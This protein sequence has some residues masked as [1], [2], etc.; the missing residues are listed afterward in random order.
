ML[1]DGGMGGSCIGMMCR[2]AAVWIVRE[3]C[4]DGVVRK[5]MGFAR[6]CCC[7]GQNGGPPP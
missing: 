7:L 2:R 1:D 5:K 4:S 6:G 3:D